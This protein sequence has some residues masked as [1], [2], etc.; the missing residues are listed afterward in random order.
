MK[1]IK[2]HIKAIA[3][4]L[5]MLVFCF[6]ILSVLLPHFIPTSLGKISNELNTE[7]DATDENDDKKESKKL[8]FLTASPLFIHYIITK[9]HMFSPEKYN[10][11]TT[12][13]SILIQP[14]RAV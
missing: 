5:F 10:L 3:S 13:I 12:H 11:A 2:A 1:N 9:I 6:K 14:P 4:L 7:K 8:E